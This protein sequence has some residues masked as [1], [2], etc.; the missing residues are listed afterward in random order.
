MS[1]VVY[2]PGSTAVVTPKGVVIGGGEWHYADD[3]RGLTSFL[4]RGDLV[5]VGIPERGTATNPAAQKALDAYW[6]AEDKKAEEESLPAA[7]EDTSDSKT[8]RRTSKVRDT[9][10]AQ[11]NATGQE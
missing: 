9:D 1:V 6:E 7:Q 8:K 2:N 5:E 3:R 4:D 10:S 11:D